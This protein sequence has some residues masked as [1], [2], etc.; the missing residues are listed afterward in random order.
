MNVNKGLS[1][2]HKRI[3]NFIRKITIKILPQYV[4][5]REFRKYTGKSINLKNPQTY[6]EKIRYIML[7]SGQDRLMALCADKYNVR[8][9]V[10]KKG[11]GFLL[12]P[13]Y[14]IYDNVD[15]IDINALPD[16]FVLKCVHGS[17]YNVIC[18][19]KAEFDWEK[20]KKKLQEWQK[21]N[22]G[23]KFGE[24]FYCH[25]KPRIICEKY[26]E[27]VNGELLDYKVHCFGGEPKMIQVDFDRYTK[28]RHTRNFYNTDWEDI[29]VRVLYPRN[30]KR[31]QEE[32]EDLK[33]MLEYARILSKDFPMVRVD[34]Y[35]IDKKIIF[36]EL[37]FAHGCGIEKIIPPEYD[38]L[39]GSW[40]DLPKR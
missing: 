8:G 39:W 4:N 32:P 15:E 30:R 3:N 9:Y 12:N 6:S 5:E 18:K 28:R 34:F 24:F 20:E 37:T 29:P 10:K 1:E 25:I 27:D 31:K 13:L 35:Y 17:A 21:E 26:L 16:Q 33:Q 7:H 36:G 14:G 11:L 2:L 38:E 23:Y 19:D 22:Y 40:I